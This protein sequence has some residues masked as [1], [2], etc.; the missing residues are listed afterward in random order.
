MTINP[1]SPSHKAEVVYEIVEHD[2][3][4][5]YKAGDTFSEAFETREDATDAARRAAA[6]QALPGPTEAIEFEDA[7]GHWHTELSDG[8]D[9]P[10]AHV[11]GVAP[12]KGTRPHKSA[13]T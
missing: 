7:S 1:D 2:G 4:W 3:G 12:A 9:R 6:E 13:R 10:E 5:A 8:G 11:E